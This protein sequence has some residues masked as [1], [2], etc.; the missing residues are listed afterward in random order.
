MRQASR[1]RLDMENTK[2]EPYDAKNSRY[3]RNPFGTEEGTIMETNIP[4]RSF[5]YQRL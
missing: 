5:D 4:R 3:T 2:S 1:A